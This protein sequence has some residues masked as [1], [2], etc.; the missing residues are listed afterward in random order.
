MGILD[1]LKR[2]Q[3]PRKATK[4]QPRD[5][6]S[7]QRRSFRDM[8]NDCFWSGKGIEQRSCPKNWRSS[9][10]I[11]FFC[12][13]A[14]LDAVTARHYWKMLAHVPQQS[15]LAE[16]VFGRWIA[17]TRR[18][19]SE[20]YGR[21]QLSFTR[22]REIRRDRKRQPLLFGPRTS[23]THGSLCGAPNTVPQALSYG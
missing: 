3:A 22:F 23:R 1:R 7:G 12:G 21:L 15:R 4:F 8:V 10:L 17:E 20:L 11:L 2:L 6:D 13:N 18:F 14:H 16:D 9:N 5:L 19:F